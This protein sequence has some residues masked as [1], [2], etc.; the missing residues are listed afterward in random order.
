MLFSYHEALKFLKEQH[1]LN[2]R[3]APWVEFLQAFNFVS[4]HK[5]GSRN[6][7]GGTLSQRY[8]LHSTMHVKVVGF[9]V[10]KELYEGDHDFGQIWKECAKEP[11]NQ[12]FLQDGYLFKGNCL[13]ILLCSLRDVIV[14]EAHSSNLGV[15][16]G[17]EKTLTTMREN[18]C[19]PQME[20]DV[21]KHIA[22]Y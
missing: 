19:W 14:F 3:H 15:N 20:R 12:F 13:C 1:K 18:F 7:V 21:R 9:E 22:R 4:K 2:R 10:L 8:S 5:A 6:Q 16:F 17:R 11:F